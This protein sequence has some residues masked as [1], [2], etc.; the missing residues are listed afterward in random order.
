M[1]W[2]YLR[3]ISVQPITSVEATAPPV[4]SCSHRRTS[5]KVLGRTVTY[6]DVPF[7]MFHKAATAQGFSPSDMAHVRYYAEELRSGAF[8]IGAPTDHVRAVGGTE[9]EDFESTV[10]RYVQNPSIIH[11][12]LEIGSKPKAIGF[13]FK[14]LATRPT[15][16]DRWE[17][18]RGYPMLSNPVLSQDSAEW[19]ATAERQ[20]L[21]LLPGAGIDDAGSV[22]N[23][24]FS[25]AS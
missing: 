25:K 5:P 20:Q 13:L 9:P 21:N 1:I 22:S 24:A 17:R 6:K 11:P 8:A 3:F 19:R 14:M 18:D 10:R 12:G 16:L 2:G 7:K 4:P 23:T 15:D